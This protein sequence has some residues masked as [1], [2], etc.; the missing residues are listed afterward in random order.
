MGLNALYLNLAGDGKSTERC[1]RVGAD[2][3]AGGFDS[4]RLRDVPR[5]GYGKAG[6]WRTSRRWGIPPAAL[7][8]I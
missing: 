6:G 2:G 5:S 4:A 3:V 8:R 7:R 1:S